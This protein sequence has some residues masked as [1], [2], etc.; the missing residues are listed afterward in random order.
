M[1]EVYKRNF[2]KGANHGTIDGYTRSKCDCTCCEAAAVAAGL[3][4]R[5]TGS[6]KT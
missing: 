6:T 5:S 1:P 3:H 4:L 2:V